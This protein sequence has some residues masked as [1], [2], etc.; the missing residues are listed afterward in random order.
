MNR[1]DPAL[2]ADLL[3]AQAAAAEVSCPTCAGRG[4]VAAGRRAG[5]Y[6]VRID[7][8]RL[9]PRRPRTEES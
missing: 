9:C 7:H 2:A 6:V 4:R 3:E 8:G 1:A 5:E